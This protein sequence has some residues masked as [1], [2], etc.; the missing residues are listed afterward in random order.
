[1][2]IHTSVEEVSERFWGELRRRVYTTPKSYL[3]LISLYLNTLG[4]KRAQ[5]NQNRNRLG[6]GLTTLKNTNAS[7]ADLRVT[8]TKMLPELAKANEELAVTLVEVNKDKAIADEK[9]KVVSAEK[10][11]VEAEAAE[12]KIIK[13]DADSELA[14]ALPILESAKKI[15]DSLDKNAIVEIKALNNPPAAVEMV[16]GC[17]M[18]ML[19]EKD[20]K[21]ESIRS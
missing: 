5:I 20:I 7:I 13:D 2:I 3:D 14:A 12:T 18:T 17:V 6:N 8:I 11:I 4:K 1:M 16:M 10:E 9:D 15:V 21:W 19:G